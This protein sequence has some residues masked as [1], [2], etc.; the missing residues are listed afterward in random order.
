MWPEK[1]ART[2]FFWLRNDPNC[3]LDWFFAPR[4]LFGPAQ[5]NI[6]RQKMIIPAKPVSLL[7]AFMTCLNFVISEPRVFL[8]LVEAERLPCANRSATAVPP[9]GS[10]RSKWLKRPRSKIITLILDVFKIM[11]FTWLEEKNLRSCG[12]FWNYWFS[13]RRKRF[14]LQVRI[15]QSRRWSEKQ[16]KWSVCN[17]QRTVA[18]IC[19]SSSS[20]Q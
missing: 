19:S 9:S 20:K 10:S 1:L 2:Q 11:R 16:Q 18:K 13:S 5:R 8:L 14:H 15:W 3:H 6:L 7:T 4:Q 12:W 17:H